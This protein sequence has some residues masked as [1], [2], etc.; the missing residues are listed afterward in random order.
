[1]L[2]Q[3]SVFFSQQPLHCGSVQPFNS[4]TARREQ[5]Q[6]MQ[7]W[8]PVFSVRDSFSLCTLTWYIK[9]KLNAAVEEHCLRQILPSQANIFLDSHQQQNSVLVE[10]F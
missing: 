9:K 5:L 6:L 1:M 4:E 10:I 7:N 3:I 8:T 2:E